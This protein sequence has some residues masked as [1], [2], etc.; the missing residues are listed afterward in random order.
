[1]IC[2][3][4]HNNLFNVILTF[5]MWLGNVFFPQILNNLLFQ[6]SIFFWVKQAPSA[7]S[8]EKNIDLPRS[9]G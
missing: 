6:L 8:A 5:F 2:L 9:C 1:M 4:R 3:L 7:G